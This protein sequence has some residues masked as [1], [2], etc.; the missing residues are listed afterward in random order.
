MHGG[1]LALLRHVQLETNRTQARPYLMWSRRSAKNMVDA[2]VAVLAGSIAGKDSE[3]AP[4]FVEYE[5]VQ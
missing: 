1:P 4:L 2:L 3:D 5:G